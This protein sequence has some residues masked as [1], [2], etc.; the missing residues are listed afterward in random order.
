MI[1]TEEATRRVMEHRLPLQTVSVPLKEATGSI[2]QETLRADR[3]FPPFH[4]VMMDGIAYKLQDI[5]END[6]LI[7]DGLQHAGEPPQTVRLPGYCLEVMTGAVLPENADTVTRYE[8]LI[9]YE[10]EGRKIAKLMVK[11][12]KKGQHVHHQGTDR[13]AG[14]ALLSPGTWLSPA[15]IAVAASVGKTHLQVSQAPVVGI[16]STGDELVDI[17][18]TPQP[19]QIRKSNTYALKA[20]LSEIRIP[21]A[22]YHLKDTKEDIRRGLTQAFSHHDVLIL[23][24]GVSKGKRDYVPEVLAEIGI[25]QVFHQVRQRPGKPFWFGKQDSKTVFALPGNPVSTF[26]C[27]YRYVAPWLRAVLG[28]P[29]ASPPYALL[30]EEVTF[31]PALTYF[32]QVKVQPTSEGQLMAQPFSGHGSGDFA[33]LLVCNGF[34]ELPANKTI[35]RQGECYP[36]IAF[37]QLL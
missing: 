15:E 24:G 16:I 31:E 32:L 36:F 10:E 29:D 22:L 12:E 6:T 30:S 3:D 21:G 26:L 37:R 14:E 18:E 25:Q 9:F 27:F 28:V 1:T 8:D 2:L 7:V 35:F 33:N 5:T 23:S 11:P 20:A 17:D 13:G 19:Y 34:L 4:R